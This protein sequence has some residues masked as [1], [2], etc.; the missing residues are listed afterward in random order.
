M[1]IFF[2]VWDCLAFFLALKEG[3]V[4]RIR[5]VLGKAKVTREFLWDLLHQSFWL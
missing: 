5:E 4:E 1:L 3:L 2:L